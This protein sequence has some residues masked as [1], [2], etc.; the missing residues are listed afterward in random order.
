M[1]KRAFKLL[2]LDFERLDDDAMRYVHSRINT[3]ILS[4]YTDGEGAIVFC[5]ESTPRTEPIVAHIRLWVDE[6]VTVGDGRGAVAPSRKAS[7]LCKVCVVCGVG[8]ASLKSCARCLSI[9]YCSKNCQAV[10][11]PLHRPACKASRHKVSI[12]CNALP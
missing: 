8:G 7:Y 6:A 12:T 11:W 4:R 9:Y 10:D 5:L 1:N 3:Y 2:L